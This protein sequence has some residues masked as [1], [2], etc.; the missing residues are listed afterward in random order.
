MMVNELEVMISGNKAGVLRQ[1]TDGSL[2]FQYLRD[3]RGVPLSSA[4]PLSTQIYKDKIIRPYLWGLLPEDPNT[5]KYVAAE[6]EV[7]YNNPF[8]L[9][10]VIGL[11]CPGAV[12][13]YV[14]DT[15]ITHEERLIPI[16]EGDIASRLARSRS[17]ESSWIA[18]NEHWSLGGQQNK[19]ALRKY[20]NGWFI[21]EGTAATT[22]ILKSG[23][24]ELA[25]QAL[26]EYICMRLAAECGI[27]TAQVEYV[28]FEG[29][30]GVEPAIVVERY[31]RLITKQHVVRLHQEDLCQALG[32]L[33]DN[34]YTMYGGSTSID[35][36]QLLMSTGSTAANNVARFLQM[37]FFNYLI[38]ATD[39]HA[40]NYS[41]MLNVSG[42]H[43]LAPMYDVASIAPYIERAQWNI[44]PPKLAMS[45][46][47]E[48]RIGYLTANHLHKMVKQCGLERVGIVEEGCI[49]QL[50][51]YADIIPEKLSDIFD[52]LE[53]TQ[54]ALSAKELR[55]YM[56]EPIVSLCKRA[57][58]R[59]LG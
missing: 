25:H 5:R 15:Q 41:L 48:N 19:F 43:R 18:D 27:D 21:C 39:G 8:A 12:Q 47:G 26:N 23:V 44:K 28:E 57:K 52:D 3:Y 17:N 16:N 55:A 54:S 32:C 49:K 53:E 20:K 30:E 29:R 2:S 46:G 10:S 33:P 4:M 37:L 11:D 13:F 1:G 51:F 24:R 58:E 6:A 31:D 36:I 22:H 7:S 59:L 50:V 56:E 42:D 9:L 35:V 45:I 34:K 14:S 38:A 40:K